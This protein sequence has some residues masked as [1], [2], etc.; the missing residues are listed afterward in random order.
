MIARLP[1]D[2]RP[3]SWGQ[4]WQLSGAVDAVLTPYYAAMKVRG[5]PYSGPGEDKL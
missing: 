1:A 3:D 4:P 2:D 5:G